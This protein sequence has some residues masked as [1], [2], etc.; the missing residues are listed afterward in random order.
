MALE[1]LFTNKKFVLL[2]R[3]LGAILIEV[4]EP[5]NSYRC[6]AFWLVIG[7]LRYLN[8]RNSIALDFWLF[9]KYL[10]NINFKKERKT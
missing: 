6:N 7:L 3:F 4:E 5:L 9:N 8:H 10:D 2:R 1:I